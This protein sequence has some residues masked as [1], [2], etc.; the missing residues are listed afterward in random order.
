MPPVDPIVQSNPDSLLKSLPHAGT[1]LYPFVTEYENMV[2]R[3]R[4]AE[5]EAAR[6]RALAQKLQQDQTTLSA[7]EG[8]ARAELQMVRAELDNKG[9]VLNSTDAQ[10][11]TVRDDLRRLFDN[12]QRK[13]EALT[14]DLARLKAEL[15][16][17]SQ[18]C[19][20]LKSALEF[21]EGT[22]KQ[23]GEVL[24]LRETEVQKLRTDLAASAQ[25]ITSLRDE[26]RTS[27]GEGERLRLTLDAEATSCKQRGELIALRDSEL[28]QTTSEVVK[29]RTDLDVALAHNRKVEADLGATC[30]TLQTTGDVLSVRNAEC[31]KMHL[32]LTETNAREMS[33]RLKVARLEQDSQFWS[34]AYLHAVQ[35]PLVPLTN[36]VPLT[37]SISRNKLLDAKA[38][39]AAFD[40]TL[41]RI[42]AGQ[43][44]Y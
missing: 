31:Q 3:V 20:R 17:S 19:E 1:S 44:V 7:S 23:R 9:Q 36:S 21:A 13:E 5:E 24:A 25:E 29:L 32:E 42:R 27:R 22:S 35:K 40:E 43:K 4:L 8:M 39:A 12:S 26:L 33:Q 16:S 34:E 18:D 14:G 41:A 10:L 6:W 30:K 28:K 38:K 2:T 15:L 37:T 11:V